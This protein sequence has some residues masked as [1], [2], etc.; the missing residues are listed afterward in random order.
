MR[1]YAV[2]G[3]PVGSRD[4]AGAV[5]GPTGESAVEMLCAV[6]EDIWGLRQDTRELVE[7][8]RDILAEARD[9]RDKSLKA[10]ERATTAMETICSTNEVMSAALKDTGVLE[11]LRD[12][13]KDRTA[14]LADAIGR[15]AERS[16]Q[17]S[18][19]R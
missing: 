10:L 14:P 17:E 12:M 4:G 9:T 5:G 7:V 6:A 2:P 8:A 13:Q 11:S 16:V 1:A 18:E 3:A 15:F 19:E